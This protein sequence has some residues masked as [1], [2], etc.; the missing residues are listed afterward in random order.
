MM[1]NDIKI[2][3]YS[4]VL[5]ELELTSQCSHLL[6]GNGFNISLGISTDYKSIFEKMIEED[7]IY[8]KIKLEIEQE[9]YDIEKLIGYLKQCIKEDSNSNEFLE[10]YIENRVKFDFMKSASL[11]VKEK[12]KEIYQDRN[13]K[14]CLL[15]KN[16]SNYFTLN[17]NTFLYLILMKFKESES[18]SSQALA[19]QNSSLFQQQN[20]DETQNRIYTE[21]EAAWKN[22]KITTEVNNEAF[23]TDLNKLTKTTFESIIKNHNR[24]N[25]KGWKP[26]DIEVVCNKI[27]Q[28]NNNPMLRVNDGFQ[29]ELFNSDEDDCNQNVFF[30]H[31]SFHIYRDGVNIKKITQKKNKAVYERLEKI[32]HANEKDIICVFTNESEDKVNQIQDNQYLNRCFNKLSNL[33]GNLVILGAS[34]D[35]NDKHILNAV[36]SSEICRLYISSSEKS[37]YKTSKKAKRFFP[38]KEVILFDYKTISYS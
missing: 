14:I 11:I 28:K 18:C 27:W 3:T 6:L 15:F 12:I 37:K 38:S 8:E 32:I 13:E 26:K 34:L 10:T 24:Q 19:F 20:L 7:S 2:I 35:E 16:F 36:N 23:D 9:S 31:G 30:L 17:Y 33:S 4:Q 5:Q 22:G 29:G 21:I 1:R 25:S